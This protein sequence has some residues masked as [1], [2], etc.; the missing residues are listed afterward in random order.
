MSQVYATLKEDKCR[1]E[2]KKKE[3][4]FI[5]DDTNRHIKERPFKKLKH[6]QEQIPIK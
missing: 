3:E 6:E 5:L 2:K 1:K 4:R